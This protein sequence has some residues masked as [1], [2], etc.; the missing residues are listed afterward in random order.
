MQRSSRIERAVGCHCND[1]TPSTPS[2]AGARILIARKLSLLLA[3]PALTLCGLMLSACQQGPTVPIASEPF[4]VVVLGGRV[5]DPESRLEAVRNIGIRGGR[6]AAISEQRLVGRIQLDAV[7]QVVAPGFIDL[8]SHGMVVPSMW[9]QA[10]DGVTT[11]LDLEGGNLPIPDAYAIARDEGRPLNYGYSAN[12]AAARSSVLADTKL[13]GHFL[14]NLAAFAKPNW[15]KLATKAQS[16]QILG[17]LEK[18]VQEGA[19]GIGLLVGYARE[20]NHEEYVGAAQIAARYGVPTFTH[21]RYSNAIEPGGA[22]EGHEELIAVAAMTGAHMHLCHLNSTAGRQLPQVVPMIREAQ[23]RGLRIT[24]EAYPYGAGS[25]IIGS[26]LFDPALLDAQ[27]ISETDIFFVPAQK[28]IES[29]EELI[30]ARKRD[31]SGPAVV[32]FLDEDNA[33][34]RAALDM[35]V[36]YPDAAIASDT[37]W[38]VRAN[39]KPVVEPVWPLPED[40]YA[41]PRGAG[42]FTKILGRYVRERKQLSLMEALRRAS[43]LPAQI[44]EDAAPQMKAKGRIKLGGDADIIVFDPD[45]VID[46]ATYANPR[47]PAQGMR[48]VIVSGVPLIRDGKLDTT[49]MPGQPVRGPV[50]RLPIQ[51]RT[52]G[53]AITEMDIM[54]AV[55]DLRA[56]VGRQ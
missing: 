15:Q 9:M 44:L 18:A 33:N 7:G 10:F 11:T 25:T 43:L 14:T 29:R 52:S 53:R 45:T 27:G 48:H 2:K 46:K 42:T 23:R 47:Q 51:S 3:M 32:S 49:V 41:H 26:Q 40:A 1:A 21:L 22:I 38:W 5:V 12:W 31:P 34:Q 20:S 8:H 19:L 30:E 55:Q 56:S 28:R 39:G 37:I 17:L 54:T 16:A 6:V 36:L 35:A 4:D 24:V 13:D 50:G